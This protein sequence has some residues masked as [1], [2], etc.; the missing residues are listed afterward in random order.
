MNEMFLINQQKLMDEHTITS[1]RLQ[2][3]IEMIIQLV[4]CYTFLIS[5]KYNMIT[6]NLG[7]QQELNADAKTMQQIHFT[8]NID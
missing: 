1:G 5:K 2:M 6:I 4:V 7:K 8:R 3:V